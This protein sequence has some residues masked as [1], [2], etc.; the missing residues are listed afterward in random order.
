MWPHKKGLG[1]R[2]SYGVYGN[3]IVSIDSVIEAQNQDQLANTNITIP[4]NDFE[5][6]KKSIPMM[7]PRLNDETVELTPKQN[8]NQELVENQISKFNINSSMANTI[9]SPINPLK[10]TTQRIEQ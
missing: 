8:S 2:L 10:E 5:M 4:H 6:S 7:F 9:N 1:N 3:A